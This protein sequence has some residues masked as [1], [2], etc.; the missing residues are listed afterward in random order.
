[1]E[2]EATVSVDVVKVAWPVPSRVGV[3][4]VEEPFLKVTVPVGTPLPGALAVTAAVNVTGWLN[5]EGLAEELTVVVVPSLF[6]TWGEAE[7]LP[8]L[9]PQPVLPVKVAVMVLLPT[10]SAGVLKA[11]WPEL[12]TARFEARMLPLSVKVTV[13]TGTPP[14]DVV[15][16]VMVTDCPNEDGLGVDVTVVVVAAEFCTTWTVLPL[17]EAKTESE[18]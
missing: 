9:F 2:C 17:L 3:P 5:T 8:L 1:M 12:F 10:P 7:S 16:E 6:T 11:A 13:P 4:R 18:A 15:V 14:P